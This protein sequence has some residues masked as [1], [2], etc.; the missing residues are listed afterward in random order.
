[1]NFE[2]LLTNPELAKNIKFE[3]TGENLLELS[4]TLISASKA[5]GLPNDEFLTR[6][7]VKKLVSRDSVTLWRWHK[8]NILTHNQIGLYKKSDIDKFLEKK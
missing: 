2:V 8:N 5:Q 4:A 3:I 7:E 6:E 1:M